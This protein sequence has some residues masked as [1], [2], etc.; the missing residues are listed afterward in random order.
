MPQKAL[1]VRTSPD[2]HDGLTELNLELEQGWRVAE[3]TPMGGAGG[4]TE[5][6][7]HAALV[8]LEHQDPDQTGPSVA[9]QTLEEVEEETEK[10]VEE[11]TQGNG[12]EPSSSESTSS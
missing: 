4:A 9:A 5:R 11:A 1:I 7:C 3:M 12:T 6:P 2:G 8:I 10:A